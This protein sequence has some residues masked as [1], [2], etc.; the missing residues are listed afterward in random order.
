MGEMKNGLIIMSEL[1]RKRSVG[2][3]ST[4]R[5]WADNIKMNFEGIWN[6]GVHWIN[7]VQNSY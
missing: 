2:N 3:K 1:E 7:L 5:R 6:E 4:M